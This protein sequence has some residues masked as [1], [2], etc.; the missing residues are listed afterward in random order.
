[1]KTKLFF[2]LLFAL[3]AAEADAQGLLKKLG[4]EVGKAVK[5]EIVNQLTGDKDKNQGGQNNPQ[6]SPKPAQPAQNT[7]HQRDMNTDALPKFSPEQQREQER[8]IRENEARDAERQTKMDR[9]KA[10]QAQVD[11][12]DNVVRDNS[13]EYIDEY[14]VNHG[15]GILIDSIVWA[16]VNCGY[17][18]TDYPYGKL[19]QWG[20]IHGQGY[21]A[22]FYRDVDSVQIDKTTADFKPAPVS[23]AEARKP[24]NKNVFYAHSKMAA[25]NWTTNDVWLWNQEPTEAEYK[26][27]KQRQIKVTKNDPCPK[28]WRV[29]DWEEM[30]KLSKNQSLWTQNA[31]G[32]NGIWFS[33]SNE[34]SHDV[35]RIFLPA[36]GFRDLNGKSSSRGTGGLYW[37]SR[38]HGGELLVGEFHVNKSKGEASQF[39]DPRNGQSIRCVRE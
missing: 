23:V 15:G 35:Q 4:N 27:Y 36:G 6:S 31:D 30:I 22:P 20:R 32:Q 1:M 33:G 11:M 19:Y 25:F 18:A 12:G 3:T 29:P 17:H 16:P 34:Y 7:N 21:G 10:L 14:G 26:N 28:G 5:K 2:L 24:E 37:T 9:L 13:V 39:G 38:H 8:Q